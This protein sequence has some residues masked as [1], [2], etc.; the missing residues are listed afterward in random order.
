MKLNYVD[1]YEKR[2]SRV[3]NGVPVIVDGKVVQDTKPMYLYA[4]TDATPE[5]LVMYK[6][7]KRDNPDGADYYREQDGVP[8]WHNPE[9]VGMTAEISKYQ[10]KDG[11]TRFRVNKAMQGA[12]EGM[13]AAFPSLG[14]KL[15]EQLFAILYSGAPTTIDKLANKPSTQDPNDKLVDTNEE[16]ETPEEDETDYEGFSEDK[17]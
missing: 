13:R 5:E 1:Y 3:V 9:F 15:D 14:S 2:T 11:K 6:R 16:V 4:V 7:F 8:L 17:N 10:D 12:I